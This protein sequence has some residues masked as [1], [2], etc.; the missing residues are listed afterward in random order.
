[1]RE[2]NERKN[3]EQ[4]FAALDVHWKHVGHLKKYRSLVPAPRNSDVIGLRYGLSTGILKSSP[5]VSISQPRFRNTP[6]SRG[7]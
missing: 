1:M 7:K 4:W 3:P 5:G 6:C 2:F